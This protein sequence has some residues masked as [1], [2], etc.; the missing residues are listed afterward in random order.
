MRRLTLIAALLLLPLIAVAVAFSAGSAPLTGFKGTIWVVERFD[1]NQNTLAAIDAETGDTLGVVPVGR[2]PI[3]VTAPPRTG[4]VYSADERSNQLTVVSKDDF[5]VVTTIPTG[6][7]PHHL[8]HN[9]HGDR[10]YVAEYN[11]RVVGVVDTG[12]DTRIGGI[13]ASDDPQARTHAVWIARNDR[14]LYATNEGLTTSSPG[15]LSKLDAETGELVW[16]IPIGNRP[17]EVLVTPDGK[18]GYVTVRNDNV[19]KV[20]DLGRDGPTIL[21]EVPIGTQPDTMRLTK[22]R[23]TLVVGLRSVPQL[24]LMDTETLAVRHVAFQ[25]W[26]ISGHQWL[27][28][29]GR[30]TFV[31]LENLVTTEH[32][33][34]G[35]VDNET[36]EIV[37]VYQYPAGPWPHG[38]FYE[39]SEQR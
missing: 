21:A 29:N 8:M 16:E 36:A 23:G 26:S 32:G 17:S 4:K 6:P 19:V 5:S 14:D 31:A 2:R 35:I 13:V 1:G 18:T 27:S 20:L 12:T 37:D 15:T 38:V 22:D 39:R 9:K 30:F 25:G 3:G 10:I 28:D 7:F 11:S 33:G 34:I 24:A